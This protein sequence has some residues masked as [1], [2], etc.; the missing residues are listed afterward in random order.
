MAGQS[1]DRAGAALSPT[2]EDALID[3]KNKNKVSPSS[4]TK[5]KESTAGATAPA[6]DT[7]NTTKG[8]VTVFGADGKSLTPF[9]L[10]LAAIGVLGWQ[11]AVAHVGKLQELEKNWNPMPRGMAKDEVI[12]N[13]Y[14][15]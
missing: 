8:P 2:D 4:Q 6:K 3:N 10:V 7:S 14:T 13:N 5:G 9:Y 1:P 11:L 15:I 12:R